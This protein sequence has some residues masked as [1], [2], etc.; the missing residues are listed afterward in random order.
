MIPN[1]DF[2]FLGFNLWGMPVYRMKRKFKLDS[3]DKPQKDSEKP[4][5]SPLSEKEIKRLQFLV[6]LIKHDK[7]GG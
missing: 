4:E 3:Q 2:E 1:Y 7:V 6:W 5:E